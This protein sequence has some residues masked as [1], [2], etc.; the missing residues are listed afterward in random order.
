MKW[1]SRIRSRFGDF[2]WY[3][4]L[5][6]IASRFGDAINIFIGAWLVPKYI[7]S[8]E[9]GAVLPLSVFS[10][11]LGL[12]IAIFGIVFLKHVNVLATEK[13]YGQLK[14]LLRSVFI[15]IAVTFLIIL[16]SAIIIMP[17]FFERIRVARGSLGILIVATGFLGSVAPIYS[18]AL[19][20]LKRFKTIS[21]L[22]I[23]GAPIRLVVMLITLPF[24][25]LASYFAAQSSISLTSI[26]ISIFSLRKEISPSV[27]PEPYWTKENTKEILRYTLFVTLYFLP[28][29]VNLIETT[30]IRQRLP[31]MDSAAYYMISRFAEIS[32]YASG[33][34]LT[35]LFPFVSEAAAKNE[36]RYRLIIRAVLA[37]IAFGLFCTVIF[38]FF[39]DRLL[40][41]LPNGE[42]YSAYTPQLSILTISLT[43]GAAL[44][45][46]ILS[47]A[48]EKNFRFLWWWLPIHIAYGAALLFITGYGYIE[49]YLPE[50]VISVLKEIN[51]YGLN[52]ILTAM[53]TLSIVK[54]LFCSLPINCKKERS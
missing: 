7:P 16:L 26:F 39:G 36:K 42:L 32:M 11:T 45:C 52:F 22:H 4:A 28:G 41:L 1:L 54:L 6:F 13:K 47:F 37:A 2:W 29:V 20:A 48:A 34:I 18:N 24:R 12:P 44:N 35:V 8:E 14:T 17:H 10:S 49:Q 53:L 50:S 23:L 15:S 30:I 31:S 43:L 38:F 51:G 33:A 5:I 9:L 21:L 46:M 40:S 27:K 25:P 3:S 19:Q